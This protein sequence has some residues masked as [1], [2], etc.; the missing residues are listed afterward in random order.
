MNGINPGALDRW[1]TGN[2]GEDHPDNV[3]DRTDRERHEA[4]CRAID[5]ERRR[6]ALDNGYCPE[7]NII[8]TKQAYVDGVCQ[9]CRHD[10]GVW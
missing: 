9:E 4:T 3:D 6:R 1:I 2:Y 5:R 8:L 7:C 10:L